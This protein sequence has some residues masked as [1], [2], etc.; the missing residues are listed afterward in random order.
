MKTK[1]LLLAL[2]LPFTTLTYSQCTPTPPTAAPCSGGNGVGSDGININSG[3][4][5]WYSGPSTTWATGINLNGGTFRVCGTLTLSNIS[6]NSGVLIIEAGGTLTINGGGSLFLNGNSS[7]CNR[8]TLNINKNVRM[9]NANNTLWNIGTGAILTVAGQIELNSSTSKL[10]NLGGQVN[11]NSI[12]VQSSASSGAVCTQAGSCFNFNAGGT[13]IIN[14]FTNGWFFNGSGQAAIT[15]NGDAQLNNNFTGNSN[16][17]ICRAPSATTSGGAGWGSATILAQP[18]PNC[19]F[20]LPIALTDFEVN[21]ENRMCKAI[22]TTESEH[23]NDYFTLEYSSDGINFSEALVEDGSGTT[24][25]KTDY[26]ATFYLNESN[27]DSIIY[28]RLK[29]TDFNGYSEY[30]EII[31]TE[32]NFDHKVSFFP[33]PFQN[34]LYFI[35]NNKYEIELLLINNQG[36]TVL[37][38]HISPGIKMIETSSINKGLYQLMILDQT[39]LKHEVFKISKF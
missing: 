37:R 21:C 17:V 25:E 2:F 26:E 7:I 32:F 31:S 19:S 18:C 13:S 12:L 6:F 34:E 9:Q 27:I 8:G 22:W 10:L 33:N 30:Y 20:A 3:Q 29:Q 24:T 39:N 23:D 5:Y 28:F 15:Y 1:T 36:N 4:T 35:N 16:F 14:N 38:E 11:A